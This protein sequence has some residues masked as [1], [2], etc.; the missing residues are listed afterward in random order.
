MSQVYPLVLEAI[1]LPW[2]HRR[3]F[4][5]RFRVRLPYRI[6]NFIIIA[7]K[8]NHVELHSGLF[9]SSLSACPTILLVGNHPTLA[10]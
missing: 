9:R 10:I 2:H 5:D 8:C 1:L 6:F 3:S 7:M 4:H